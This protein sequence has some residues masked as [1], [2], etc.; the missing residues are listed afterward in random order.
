MKKVFLFVSVAFLGVVGFCAVSCNT[1]QA[2]AVAQSTPVS[3]DSL[4]KRGQYLVT[5]MGCQDC[6]SPKI[7]G[8]RGPEIDKSKELSG[9]PAQMPLA[10]I[11]PAT[12][13][14]WVLFNPISTAVVGPWGVS[15]SSNLTSSP[16]GIGSW[17]EERF[18]KAIR[19]GKAKGLDNNRMMLP[20][21]PWQN[22]AQATDD[23]LKAIFAYLKSTKPVDNVVPE[24]IAPGQIA[25]LGK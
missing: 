6:H 11:D 16:S 22:I 7:M 3:H 10:T 23:D 18:F 4:V 9:H 8:P 20:P 14:S 12:M 17:T 15:F 25:K 13:K 1:N 21:M 24:P 19:E 5:V 2:E